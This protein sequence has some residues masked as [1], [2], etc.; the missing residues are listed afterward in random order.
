MG[1][2]ALSI[3]RA[4]GLAAEKAERLDEGWSERARM[5]RPATPGVHCP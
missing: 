3:E 4:A 1:S 5:D 2:I